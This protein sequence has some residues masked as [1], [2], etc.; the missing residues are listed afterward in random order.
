MNTMPGLIL[1][2]AGAG[3]A[4]HRLSLQRFLHKLFMG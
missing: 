1:P 3:V 2:Q 4:R